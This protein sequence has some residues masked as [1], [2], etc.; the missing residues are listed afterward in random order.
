MDCEDP[1]TH[2]VI[3]G[4]WREV[5]AL[6]GLQAMMRNNATKAAKVQRDYLR[7]YYNSPAGSVPWQER[8][9]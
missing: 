5:D 9:I 1:D 6:V 3:P 4:T 2:Q 8:M 7:Q